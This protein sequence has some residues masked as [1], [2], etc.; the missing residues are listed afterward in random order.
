MI[1][2]KKPSA[3]KEELVCCKNENM[4]ETLVENKFERNAVIIVKQLGGMKRH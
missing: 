1:R 4:S 3:V 2:R